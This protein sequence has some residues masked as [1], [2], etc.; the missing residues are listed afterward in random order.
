MEAD[1]APATASDGTHEVDTHTG[2]PIEVPQPM[3]RGGAASPSG[4]RHGSSPGS[5]SSGAA[6]AP[7]GALSRSLGSS[8]DRGT[9][10]H[11]R[12]LWTAATPSEVRLYPLPGPHQTTPFYRDR[13]PRPLSRKR[14]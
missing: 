8:A 13:R 12:I 1:A 5:N 2:R 3:N 9:L 10:P 11:E 4:Q 7:Q 14:Q 6:L